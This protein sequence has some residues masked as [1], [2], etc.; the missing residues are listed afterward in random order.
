MLARI[1]LDQR[2]SCALQE[3]IKVLLHSLALLVPPALVESLQQTLLQAVHQSLFVQSVHQAMQA[4]FNALLFMP[5]LP[6][7]QEQV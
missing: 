7:A 4:Q 3:R 1:S 5:T 2:A 6:Y